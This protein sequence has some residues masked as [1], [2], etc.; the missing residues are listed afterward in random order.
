MPR[1]TVKKS[2]RKVLALG[3]SALAFPFLAGVGLAQRAKRAVRIVPAPKATE[4]SLPWIAAQSGIFTELGLEAKFP[5]TA[6]DGAAALAAL[7][8]GS[9][10]LA[11]AGIAPLAQRRLAGDDPVFVATVLEPNKGGFLVAA[12]AIREPQ[13]LAGIRVGVLSRDGP[14]AQAAS[15]VLERAGATATLVVHDSFDT[16]YAALAAGAIDAGWLP[17]DLSFKGRAANSWNAFEGVRL[18]LPGGYATSRRL[19]AKDRGVVEAMVKGIVTAIH[20]F[21]TQPQEVAALLQRLLG[22][23]RA[24]AADLQAF[25]APLF[26]QA[27][28][29]S[30][31][32]GLPALRASLQSRYPAA[33][34]LQASDLIDASLVEALS[35]SG[36]ITRLYAGTR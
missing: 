36:Y 32:F 26:L 35:T 7:F 22:V 4:T 1:A 5:S 21:K 31:Y 2:R 25:Y 10:D 19:V 15:A 30:L 23:E 24:I 20:Y 18:T 29:P 13:L 8:D 27:P 17:V 9:A 6:P 14:S 28:A 34:R 3:A 11:Y 12:P 16:I 33:A